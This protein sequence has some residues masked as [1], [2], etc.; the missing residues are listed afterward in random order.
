[1]PPRNLSLFRRPEKGFDGLLVVDDGVCACPVSAP[2]AA[3]EAPGR[4]HAGE[5]IPDVRERIRFSGERASAA[6]LDHHVLALGKVQ[7]LWRVGPRL[8]RG[9][10]R[11][12]LQDSQMVDEEARIGVAIDQGP[13]IGR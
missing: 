4:E 1:M 11:A 10:W 2:Q 6:H 9:R 12:G 13:A 8:R 7:H 5:R 3:V